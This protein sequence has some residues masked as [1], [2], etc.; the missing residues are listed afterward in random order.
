MPYSTVSGMMLSLPAVAS[1]TNITSSNMYAFL[2]RGQSIIDAKIARLYPLPLTSTIPIL[3]P[4]NSDLAVYLMLRRFFTQE[5]SN[6]SAWVDRYKDAMGLLDE[7]ASGEIPLLDANGTIVSGNTNLFE[8]WTNNIDFQPTMTEDA[9]FL[10]EVDPDKIREIRI[11][12]SGG[13]EDTWPL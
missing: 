3:E 2:V 1:R 5:K 6:D 4:I 7:I 10:Q 12:R 11:E 13:G 8:I 9:T